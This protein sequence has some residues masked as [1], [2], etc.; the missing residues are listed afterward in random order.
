MLREPASSVTI[1]GANS[2]RGDNQPLYVID[3]IPQASTGEFANSGNDGTFTI[4]TQCIE[5]FESRPIL[6]V[7]K[8]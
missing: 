7:S 5:L 4:A 1:R 6:K 8:C 2:L 3:N